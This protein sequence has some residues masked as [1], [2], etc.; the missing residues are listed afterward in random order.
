MDRLA[1]LLE[2]HRNDPGD[3]FTRFALA[4]E[5]RKAGDDDRALAFFEGLVQDHP[6][7]VGTYYHLGKL[8]ERL[9]RDESAV[10][11]YRA[12]VAAATRVGDTHARAE[13][14]GAL[15]AAEGLGFDD[16]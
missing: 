9:G 8:Y 15:L 16:D 2:F 11:A 6:D 13:L 12:G 7:Y 1:T 14:Q 3:P 10:A 4:Q 5:Y